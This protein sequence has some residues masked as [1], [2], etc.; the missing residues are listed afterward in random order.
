MQ[1]I[2]TENELMIGLNIRTRPALIKYLNTK[3]IQFET[4]KR[5]EVWTV[6]QA[7]NEAVL[8][9]SIESQPEDEWVIDA[10]QT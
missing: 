10:S 9:R 6:P 1:H 4:T 3:G 7:L 5:G 2:V 8:K